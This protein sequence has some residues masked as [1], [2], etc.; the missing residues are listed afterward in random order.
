MAQ[1]VFKL[2]TMFMC[3]NT[4]GST[5]PQNRNIADKELLTWSI[6]EVVQCR[7][8]LHSFLGSFSGGIHLNTSSATHQ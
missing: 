8:T 7:E 5:A 2:S 3:L 1:S 6:L 4:V